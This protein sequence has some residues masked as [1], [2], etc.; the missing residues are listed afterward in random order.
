MATLEGF[1][2]PFF[3]SIVN[4]LTWGSH[5]FMYGII[6]QLPRSE[7]TC[8]M[9]K[10]YKIASKRFVFRTFEILPKTP[11]EDLIICEPCAIREYGDKK[12]FKEVFNK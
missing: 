7:I 3:P 4:I 8:Q 10:D 6:K 5:F 11:S 12:K 2:I 9:C 1:S